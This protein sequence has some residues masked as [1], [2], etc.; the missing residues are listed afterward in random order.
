MV[1]TIFFNEVLIG[2]FSHLN[3]A[4]N[5]N[6]ETCQNGWQFVSLKKIPIYPTKTQTCTM[7][8]KTAYN[9]TCILFYNL[10]VVM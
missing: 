2:L 10:R 7:P 3:L 8:H 6:L 1:I 4:E 5:L 9:M